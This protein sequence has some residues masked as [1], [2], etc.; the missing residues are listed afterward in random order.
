MTRS[1]AQPAPLR[2][3]S[4]AGQA[5][6]LVGLVGRGI[7]LSR[8]PAMHEAEARALGMSYVYRLIDAEQL[9]EPAP[10]LADIV[11]FAEYF[12]FQGLN[13]TFPYKQEIIP[14]LDELVPE[15]AELGSVNTVVLRSGRRIGH[16]TDLSGFRRSFTIELGDAAR[17]SVLL[18]GAGGA[19]AAVAYGLL[20]E[21]IGRLDISDLDQA[22]AAGLAA[23]LNAAFGDGRAAATS[24]M[25]LAA[26][27]ADGIVNATPV[28]MAKLPG[29]PIDAALL[30]PQCW[31]ADIVYFPLE[32]ELLAE[33]RRLGCRTMSGA[34][35][36][37]FQAVR[38]FELFTGFAPDADRMR[39]AFSA[40]TADAVSDDFMIT[41]GRKE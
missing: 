27:A 10:A 32:T 19:G 34:G 17:G 4:A 20:Q 5:S 13:V 37:V 29:I 6:T 3:P 30:R 18:L 24:D 2:A 39:A 38:A 26:A 14:L 21:G 25:S 22:K 9:G 1:A 28:G 7:Q 11:A 16:N 8:T 23:R 33:A 36:A 40:F 41:I 35:M 31:V 15:A 12:G